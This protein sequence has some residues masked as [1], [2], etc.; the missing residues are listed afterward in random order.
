MRL[1][2]AIILSGVAG[3]YGFKQCMLILDK[4]TRNKLHL[5]GIN[6]NIEVWENNKAAH[7]LVQSQRTGCSLS[8]AGVLNDLSIL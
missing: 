7:R 3:E 4:R 1:D 2:T 5:E 8:P 6:V